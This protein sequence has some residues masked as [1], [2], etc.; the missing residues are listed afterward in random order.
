MVILIS[1]QKISMLRIPAL[2]IPNILPHPDAIRSFG[3]NRH[4]YEPEFWEFQ[5][6][7]Y[8]YL[9]RL[10]ESDLIKRYG[11][12]IRNMRTVISPDRHIIPIRSFLSSWYWYRKEHQTR[13]EFFLRGIEV[14]VEP[15]TGVLDNSPANAPVRPKSPNAGDILFR[16]GDR[17]WM[18]EMFEQGSIRI[19]PAS[20]YRS[21][22]EDCGRT[23]N[24]LEKSSF[25]PGE[26]TKITTE[27]GR[28][29][30][31][32]G[33]FQRTISAPDFFVLS[34][35]CDW[36]S[37]LFKEFGNSCV[38]IRDTEEFAQR[39][40]SAAK[41]HLD[42]WLFYHNPV[43]YYDPY[44]MSRYEYFDASMC[45]DFCFAYQREYRFLWIN[46]AGQ[47]AVGFK[48]LDVGPLVGIAELHEYEKRDA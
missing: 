16:Y 48:F 40:E 47:E 7:V 27:D 45:K 20:F 14:P 19:A 3:D 10:Q 34:M 1:E 5:Y 32:K 11:Y 26:Y 23:D 44:E 9:G 30:P 2:Q 43:H 24:E 39:L 33:D 35:A 29:I 18:H 28:E 6:E 38:V 25:K 21:L 41:Y 36:D 22:E 46:T 8:R 15:P 13:L 12:I 4:S 31:I 17:Q 37:A 42:G